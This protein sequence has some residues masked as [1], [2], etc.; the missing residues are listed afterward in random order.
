MAS[1]VGAGHD[2]IAMAGQIFTEI[3]VLPTRRREA[4]SVD[5]GGVGPVFRSGLP[6]GLR[7]QG[8]LD[9]V[10]GL[11]MARGQ[12]GLDRGGLAG[13][14]EIKVFLGRDQL[15][16]AAEGDGRGPGRR[17]GR[18]PDKGLDRP[19]PL[20]RHGPTFRV[21]GRLVCSGI[22]ILMDDAE[23]DGVR[24]ER[25]S[26]SEIGRGSRNSRPNESQKN[27]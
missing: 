14:V 21:E 24:S 17:L 8:A 20:A 10:L 9:L 23:A 3:R 22:V 5:H 12:D 7:R 6:V 1:H 27:Q 18:V 13:L 25:R 4:G 26:K 15:K 11:G 19:G 16:V 2:D